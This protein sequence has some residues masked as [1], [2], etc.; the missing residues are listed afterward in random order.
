MTAPTLDPRPGLTWKG[1]SPE[2]VYVVGCDPAADNCL[3]C[4]QP[5]ADEDQDCD[6]REPLH[7]ECATAYTAERAQEQADNRA[8]MERERNYADNAADAD[9]DT[10]ESE[11]G[12]E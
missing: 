7:C 12:T 6:S 11:G 8:E 2:N 10:A 3:H 5:V 9:S 4:S 1:P